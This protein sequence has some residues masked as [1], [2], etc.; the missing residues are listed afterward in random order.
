M[1]VALRRRY[2]TEHALKKFRALHESTRRLVFG[3]RRSKRMRLA[4]EAA[5]SAGVFLLLFYGLS[6]VVG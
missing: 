1:E 4:G 2:V 5:K 3:L 6:Q